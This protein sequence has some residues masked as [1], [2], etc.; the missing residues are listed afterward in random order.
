MR[1]RIEMTSIIPANA[2]LFDFLKEKVGERKT[3]TEAYCDLLDKA[4]AGF[5][6][7]FL[8]NQ[9]VGLRPGQCH[10][11]VSDLASEWRWHR[12]TVRSFLDTLEALGQLERIKLP[13]SMIITMPLQSNA[14]SSFESVQVNRGLIQQLKEVLSGWVNG[15]IN[16]VDAGMECGNIVH[17]VIANVGLQPGDGS[18]LTLRSLSERM[19]EKVQEIRSTA[20]ECIVLAAIRK[21]LRKSRPEESKELMEYFFLNLKGSWP[22]FIDLSTA[23]AEQILNSGE[24][25]DVDYDEEQQMLLKGLRVPFMAVA[26]TGMEKY[27]GN[28]AF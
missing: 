4:Q 11:T 27:A 21:A 1:N 14:P 3:R 8:R 18:H 9:N 7:S 5:I 15:N 2:G 22:S 12:A 23:L 26:A 13:K 19:D 17:K 6:S 10:V 20:M 28:A 24:E 25:M 16:S